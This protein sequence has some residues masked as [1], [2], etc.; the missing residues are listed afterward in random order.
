MDWI[1]R[2]VDRIARV[3]VAP[4]HPPRARATS[5]SG[6]SAR[7]A[8]TASSRLARQAGR[9]HA[10]KATAPEHRRGHGVR[11]R[12]VRTDLV[13]QAPQQPRQHR[14][15]TAPTNSPAAATPSPSRSTSSR[16]RARARAERHA[17][18]DLAGALAGGEPEHPGQPDR[19]EQQRD[20]AEHRQAGCREPR[21]GQRV[22]HHR[23][24][25]R[26]VEQ[27]QPGLQRRRLP[28]ERRDH[29]RRLGRGAQHQVVERPGTLLDGT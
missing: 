4:T 3:V 25:R 20:P 22:P 17:D 18:P 23:A 13:E 29:A 9:R 1:A 24:D 11:R 10:A 8:T 28:P 14:A 12:V 26:H 19:G 5:G 15:P 27:P 16:M 2:V 21:P 7:S 6:Y